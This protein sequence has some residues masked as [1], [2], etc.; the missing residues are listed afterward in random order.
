MTDINIISDYINRINKVIDFIEAN[1]SED[2]KLQDL[3]DVACFSQFHFHRIFAMLMG[4]TPKDFLR[5]IRIERA[6]LMLKATNYNMADIAFK[7]GFSSQATFSRAFKEYFDVSPSAWKQSEKDRKIEYFNSKIRKTNSKEGK[8]IQDSKLYFD[9][10]N[11]FLSKYRIGRTDMKVSIQN[12]D[13]IHV[14]YVA[15][16]EGYFDDKIEVA[17]EKL[18]AWAG[19]KGLLCSGSKY[20]G[21]SFDDPKVTPKDKCRYYACIEVPKDVEVSGEFGL[22]DI[23]GGRYAVHRVEVTSDEI[24]KFYDELTG[25]WIPANGYEPADAPS[26][27][28]YHKTPENHPEGK[29]DMSLCV[30]V[31]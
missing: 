25:A 12:F 5:R 26:I 9:S 23:R 16:H 19:P 1:L 4:E 29:F 18:C 7:C 15:N 14:A 21:I 30:P 10:V 8:S 24:E 13:D 27:E 17:W 6:A 11:M 2:I 22:F 28:I 20:L 3:A 31:K